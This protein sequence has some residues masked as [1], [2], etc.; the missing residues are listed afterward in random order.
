MAQGAEPGASALQAISN[1]MVRLHKT[2]FGRGPTNA[3]A[4]FA[5]PDAVLCLLEDALLPAERKMV[6]LGNAGRVR[7][8]RVAF[9]AATEEEFKTAVEDILGRKVHSFSSGVDPSTSMVFENFYFHPRDGD[10]SASPD[11]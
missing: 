5:G 7:D 10:G 4:Y 9:Q 2:Q 6:E 11:A 1:A 3:R 8:T